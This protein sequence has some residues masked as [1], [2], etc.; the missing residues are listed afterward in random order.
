MSRIQQTVVLD[1][2]TSNILISVL[3]TIDQLISKTCHFEGNQRIQ[4]GIKKIPLYSKKSRWRTLLDAAVHASGA[5][6]K[7]ISPFVPAS[8]AKRKNT[9]DSADKNTRRKNKQERQVYRQAFLF[10]KLIASQKVCP[11][12]IACAAWLPKLSSLAAAA[13]PLDSRTPCE[14]LLVE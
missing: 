1:L 14:Q 8:G 2:R 12:Q 9:I 11:Y 10:R 13:S 4:R 5:S 3:P 6:K 7:L